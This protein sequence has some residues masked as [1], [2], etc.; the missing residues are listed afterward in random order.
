MARSWISQTLTS[1]IADIDSLG[2]DT[3]V[4]LQQ[5][6]AFEWRVELVYR[7]LLAKEICGEIQR[8]EREVLPLLADAYARIWQVVERAEL[9]PTLE[10]PVFLNGSLGRPRFHIPHNRLEHLVYANFTMP[11]IAR[12]VGVSVSTVR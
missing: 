6:E 2:E 4:S 1:V 11:Q 10:A 8:E 9:I 3:E 5:A 12:L 7:D